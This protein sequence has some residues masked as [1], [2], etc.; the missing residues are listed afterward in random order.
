MNAQ[1]NNYKSQNVNINQTRYINDNRRLGDRTLL[2]N[3]I[4]GKRY[5]SSLDAEIYFGERYVDEIVQITWGVEQATMPLFGY[6]SYTFDDIA[7]G[8]RQVNGSFVINFT[9]SGFMYDVLN[10]VQAINRSSLN[11]QNSAGSDA[12]KLTWASHFDKEH[13]ASWDRSFNIRV[14]YGDQ[15]KGGDNTTMIVLYCVQLT[16]CQ[17]AIGIDGAP[18]GEVYTFIAKD[19]RYELNSLPE[20]TPAEENSKSVI[21]NKIPKDDFV[22][23]LS[24][25]N[26]KKNSVRSDALGNGERFHKYYGLDIEYAVGGGTVKAIL[27]TLKRDTGEKINP[28]AISMNMESKSFVVPDE[29]TALVD[30]AFDS[31]RA[32][33]ASEDHLYILCDFKIVYEKDGKEKMP[34]YKNNQKVYLAK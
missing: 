27:A 31:Q 33:G 28:A 12:S 26:I 1:G 7:V 5:F 32:L 23:T 17:Q 20:R 25:K 34:I 18:I 4:D 9:K 3:T 13:S 11:A 10:S 6:N 15:T 2:S 14:G 8:A 24:P 22:I 21:D 30:R 29:Y 19:I 16:G